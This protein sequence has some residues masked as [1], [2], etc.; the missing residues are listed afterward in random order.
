MA[1]IASMAADWTNILS[2]DGRLLFRLLCRV[3]C[4]TSPFPSYVRLAVAWTEAIAR[5]SDSS[6]RRGLAI[7]E[8]GLWLDER[9]RW[10][11]G[12]APSMRQ[13]L[14][15][16]AIAP[17]A[18]TSIIA[19]A[20]DVSIG[21]RLEVDAIARPSIRAPPSST[22]ALSI[23]RILTRLQWTTKAKET[24]QAV[25]ASSRAA[26]SRGDV[27]KLRAKGSQRAKKS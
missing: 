26:I 25:H 10:P 19:V 23:C 12:S 11:G 22:S 8:A 9:R 20:G 4:S 21:R 16:S 14:Y 2:L 7:A 5:F 13:R 6:W 3:V 24:P 18:R 27:G 17:S 15:G 1:T